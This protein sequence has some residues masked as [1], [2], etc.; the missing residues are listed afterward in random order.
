MTAVDENFAESGSA[1]AGELPM[2]RL[3]R[4]ES[5]FTLVELLL[6]CTLMIVVLGATLTTFESFQ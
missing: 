6:V 4:E 5:G 3:S 2:S 1:S